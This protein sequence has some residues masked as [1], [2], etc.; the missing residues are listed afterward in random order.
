[1]PVSGS[2][3]LFGYCSLHDSVYERLASWLSR[4]GAWY[5]CTDTSEESPASAFKMEETDESPD[6][7]S[8]FLP[9]FALQPPH[10]RASY[11]IMQNY[12]A[13]LVC[14]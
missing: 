10:Y 4:Q 6:Y 3:L 9:R 1:M 11:S 14:M 12:A 5:V 13:L 8:K 2:T 7:V